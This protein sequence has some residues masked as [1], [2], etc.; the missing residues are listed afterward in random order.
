MPLGFGLNFSAC[1]RSR[2]QFP[3]WQRRHRRSQLAEFQVVHVAASSDGCVAEQF[4]HREYIAAVAERS[5]REAMSHGVGADD[6]GRD[7]SPLL[8]LLHHVAHGAGGEPPQ[9]P[10]PGTPVVRPEERP[11]LPQ[12]AP[13]GLQVGTARRATSGRT[14]TVL[15]FRPLPSRTWSALPPEASS[16]RRRRP[17]RP[18]AR[19]PRSAR[20]WALPAARRI[21]ATSV[22]E[23]ICT[24]SGRPPAVSGVRFAQ[25]LWKACGRRA[26]GTTSGSCAGRAAPGLRRGRPG[27]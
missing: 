14:G 2:A 11:W 16:A 19:T 7:A 17:A 23:S 24:A 4:R 3:E 26:H 18:R 10:P 13:G 5:D 9:A 6:L 20:S 1:C 12:V 15:D 25:P 22:S 27:G 21:A 8:R